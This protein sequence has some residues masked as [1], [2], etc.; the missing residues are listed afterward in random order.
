M[1]C[2]MARLISY[3]GVCFTYLSYRWPPAPLHK[4]TQCTDVAI[5]QIIEICAKSGQV[6]L[7][8]TDKRFRLLQ[9]ILKLL[10]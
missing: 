2:Q 7:M 5:C 9:M 10:N 4:K 6:L 1:W 3:I 8:H